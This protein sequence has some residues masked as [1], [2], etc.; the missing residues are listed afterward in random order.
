MRGDLQKLDLAQDSLT[1]LDSQYPDYAQQR[2]ALLLNRSSSFLSTPPLD[3]NDE[4]LRLNAMLVSLQAIA[5]SPAS[6]LRVTING[7]IDGHTCDSVGGSIG[8]SDHGSEIDSTW[9]IDFRPAGLTLQSDG[10]TVRI[11]A[12]RPEDQ[13]LANW[14]MS[15][16]LPDASLRQRAITMLAHTWALSMQ[17][18]FVLLRGVDGAASSAQE[19]EAEAMMVNFPSGWQ[20]QDKLG[21]TLTQIHQPVADG[22]ALRQASA[23]LSQALSQK[24]P[25]QRY[26]WTLSDT[27]RLNRHPGGLQAGTAREDTQ[28][29]QSP[30][31]LHEIW[32]RCERQTSLALPQQRRVLFLIRVYVAPL[33]QAADSPFKRAALASALRSMSGEVLAYKNISKL[34]EQV[35]N[36]WG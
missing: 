6:G 28:L 36:A 14:L 7:S 13:A 26:V 3:A 9:Q 23:Q 25:F 5:T 2:L 33:A 30:S 35:L 22:Q 20:P 32:F 15:T 21:G 24:G 17:E 31:A 18:D 34:R 29:M 8:G 16:P 10:D 27:A 12:R 4:R 19:I 11:T 1:R